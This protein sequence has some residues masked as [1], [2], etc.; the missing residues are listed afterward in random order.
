MSALNLATWA[1][2]G[3]G[4]VPGRQA[5]F[6]AMSPMTA[7]DPFSATARKRAASL[8][9]VSPRAMTWLMVFSGPT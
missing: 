2:S 9:R 7:M 6:F 1:I 8:G 3:S 5:E 4:M